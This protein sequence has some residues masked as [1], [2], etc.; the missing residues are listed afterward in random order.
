MKVLTLC[1][2][3]LVRSHAMKLTMMFRQHEV[4]NAGV[5]A[6]STPTLDM[7]CDWADLILTA[8]N[9]MIERIDPQYR[10][11]VVDIA[12]GPDRW[13]TRLDKD[14]LKATQKAIKAALHGRVLTAITAPATVSK[15]E[16]VRRLAEKHGG[17]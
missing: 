16:L 5:E 4:L 13:K 7:L 1:T 2:L 17:S 6:I 3:G 10:N 12:L 9:Y 14:L 15:S 11:K 8:E